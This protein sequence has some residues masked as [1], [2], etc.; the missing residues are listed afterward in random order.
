MTKD[1]GKVVHLPPSS[2][3]KLKA[4]RVKHEKQ[5]SEYASDD[6]LISTAHEALVDAMM[7]INALLDM[8]SN[9]SH[10]KHHGQ[11][12]A[13]YVIKVGRIIDVMRRG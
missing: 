4:I 7:N 3:R 5:L 1:K 6:D 10:V 13:E 11:L 9:E 12:A 2:A 8:S